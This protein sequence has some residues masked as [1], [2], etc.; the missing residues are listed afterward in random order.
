M[1]FSFYLNLLTTDILHFLFSFRW[2]H[3]DEH[4]KGAP[5]RDWMDFFP[6]MALINSVHSLPVLSFVPPVWSLLWLQNRRFSFVPPPLYSLAMFLHPSPKW[7]PMHHFHSQNTGS[8]GMATI[9][10]A[11]ITTPKKDA[12]LSSKYPKTKQLL[13]LVLMLQAAFIRM[14][15]QFLLAWVGADNLAILLMWMCLM[16]CISG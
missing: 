11:P 1:L 5:I 15:F 4:D 3:C 9:T 8:W 10:G 7:F 13:H 16:L 2:E 12:M 6:S 14:D